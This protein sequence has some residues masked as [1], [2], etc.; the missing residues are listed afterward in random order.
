MGFFYAKKITAWDWITIILYLLTSVGLYFFFENTEFKKNVLFFYCLGSHF[1]LFSF[2]YKSLRN[3]KVYLI[4]VGFAL[5]HLYF[6]LQL[7]DVNSLQNFQGHAA[8]GLASTLILLVL[9]QVLRYISLK[10]QGQELVCPSRSLTDFFDNRIITG[11]DFLL[12]IVYIAA[13]FIL[14]LY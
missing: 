9:F 14:I 1:F 13:C 12:F 6:Y 10:T 8:Q 5:V 4:W 7:K 3:F 2:N 11:I